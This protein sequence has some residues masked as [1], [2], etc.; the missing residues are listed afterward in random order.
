MIVAQHRECTKYHRIIHLKVLNFVLWDFHLNKTFKKIHRNISELWE[1]WFAVFSIVLSERVVASYSWCQQ[2]ARAPVSACVPACV[3]AK[4]ISVK[5]SHF[6]DCFWV[7]FSL[8]KVV[9][10]CLVLIYWDPMFLLSFCMYLV[11]QTY[12]SLFYFVFYGYFFIVCF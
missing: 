11:K 6:L 3:C 5:N 9:F 8:I 10:F 4:G 7:T 1:I 12:Y 2:D